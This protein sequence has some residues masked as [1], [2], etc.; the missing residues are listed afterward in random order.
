MNHNATEVTRLE[1]FFVFSKFLQECFVL[2][3]QP[4]SYGVCSVAYILIFY[5]AGCYVRCQGRRFQLQHNFIRM[6]DIVMI[7]EA[8]VLTCGMLQSQVSTLVRAA[9]VSRS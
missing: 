1:Q 4:E 7:K 3:V 6:P 5:L 9:T 8:D 2:V